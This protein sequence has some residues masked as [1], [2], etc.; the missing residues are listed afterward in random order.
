MIFD[1]LHDPAYFTLFLGPIVFPVGVLVVI[2]GGLNLL[3]YHI[4]YDQS[5]F[6]EEE[7]AKYSGMLEQ[8]VPAI[9]DGIQVGTPVEDIANRVE[10]D[11]GIPPLITMK[12]ILTLGRIQKKL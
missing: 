6:T 7:A 1:Y 8:A 5:L 9:V 12:Y 3:N 11:Y 2:F 4:L 10:Q